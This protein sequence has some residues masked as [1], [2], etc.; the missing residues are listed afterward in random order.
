MTDLI[1]GIF[2]MLPFIEPDKVQVRTEPLRGIINDML[3]LIMNA[4]N[5]V[6]LYKSDGVAG[7]FWL[8]RLRHPL[9]HVHYSASLGFFGFFN[10]P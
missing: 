8:F 4:S 6:L 10:C 5:F 9:R 3:A 1:D 2:H 7:K